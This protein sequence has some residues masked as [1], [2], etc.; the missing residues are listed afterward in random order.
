VLHVARTGERR[1]VYR[2]V[3][4]RSEGKGPFG[5]PGVNFSQGAETPSEPGPPQYQG[6]TITL[7]HTTLGRTPVD[8]QPVVQ[9]AT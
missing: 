6:S 9:T 1:G 4:G 5:R 7:R 2:V 8:E 3:V